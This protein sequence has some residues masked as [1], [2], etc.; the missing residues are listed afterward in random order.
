MRLMPRSLRAR[1]LVLILAAL[2]LAQGLSLWLFMDERGQAVRA[3]LAQEAA[4]RAANI[5]VLLARAPATLRPSILRAASSPLV[6]FSL[7]DT[8]IVTRP[9]DAGASAIARRIRMLMDENPAPDIRVA[10]Y[11]RDGSEPG[12][13]PAMP[14]MPGMTPEMQSAMR[15]MSL[16]TVQMN[17]SIRLPRLGWLNVVSRFHSPPYQWAGA[18]V[19]TFL[20]TA[21][22]I[23][24]VLWLAVGRLTGP[25]AALA[26]AAD[27]LGHDGEVAEVTPTGPDEV[28]RLTR[29]LND[30]QHR[31]KKFVDDRTR[32]LAA[33]GHDLRSPLTALRL[34]AEMVE[35]DETREHLVASIEEMQEMVEA[36]LAFARGMA[37]GE[38][39]EREDPVDLIGA[40]VDEFTDRA[41]PVAFSPPAGEKGGN[42]AAVM[43][44]PVAFRRAL[45]NI[46]ENAL[47]Y[48]GSAE[49]TLSIGAGKAAIVVSDRGPGIPESDM[50]RVF[51]PFV[52]LEKS[53]SRDTGGTG[54]GLSIARTIIRA[55]GG[56]ITLANRPG[57]GL[58]VTITLPLADRTAPPDR[59]DRTDRD[60]T[61]KAGPLTPL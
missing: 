21:G 27:R 10:L 60:P 13:G 33:L 61:G 49:V 22:L 58:A 47:R 9:G 43:V 37:T 34:R 45:R 2:A 5:A 8:A 16:E 35:D 11:R 36:T 57:S 23:A 40:V 24:L 28:R 6:R 46:I 52:R 55:E 1:F 17:I 25:L 56:E 41:A 19:A 7:D 50:S 20:F 54:L 38:P 12:R 48:G 42:R 4:G 39:A 53:R 18:E 14:M 29:A 59:T 30:M 31:I 51:D 3:A 15:A 32:L 26:R 44:H